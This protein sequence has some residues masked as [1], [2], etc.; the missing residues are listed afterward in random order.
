[1]EENIEP[2][3]DMRNLVSCY[4]HK[5]WGKGYV[6]VRDS[7]NKWY[8]IKEDVLQ[9]ILKYQVRYLKVVRKQYHLHLEEI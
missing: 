5:D 4:S 9:K 1:M 2:D 7:L 3:F 8:K 6:M